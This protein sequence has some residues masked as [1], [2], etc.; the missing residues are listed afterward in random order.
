MSFS[1][2]EEHRKHIQ[3]SHPKEY[4]RCDMC[5]KIFNSAA[6]LEKHMVS[7]VGGKPYSC[8]ICHKA[9]QVRISV[10]SGLSSNILD[11]RQKEMI[12]NYFNFE[13]GGGVIQPPDLGLGATSYP[14]S[15][16]VCELVYTPHVQRYCLTLY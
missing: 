7:H 11:V 14:C 10:A 4:H 3:E 12:L 9:Y 1:S 13:V 6:L 8:K 2:L 16:C 15:V 5:N